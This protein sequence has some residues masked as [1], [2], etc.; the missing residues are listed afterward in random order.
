MNNPKNILL[1]LFL[2]GFG[3]L[4]HSQD[5]DSIPEGKKEKKVTI[6]PMPVIAANPTTGLVYGVA[7]GF[8]WFNGNPETTSM[9]SFL[10]TF[11]YTQKTSC[12]SR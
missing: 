5:T 6:I 2:F 1:I 4:S 8:N 11:L 10:G 7:P 3:N 12:F 9:T